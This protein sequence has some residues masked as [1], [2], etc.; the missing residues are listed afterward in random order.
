MNSRGRK[1]PGRAV[2]GDR[3]SRVTRRLV[4]RLDNIHNA[5]EAASS[6]IVPAESRPGRLTAAA[7]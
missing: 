6:K 7:G 4:S 5:G 1:I 3:N 2:S